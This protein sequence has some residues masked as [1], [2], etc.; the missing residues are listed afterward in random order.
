MT[1]Q[2]AADWFIPHWT[3]ADKLRKIRRS[4]GLSQTELADVLERNDRTVAAWET[5]RN[6]PKDIV[7]VA[8][9]IQMAYG[10]P[11]TW[12]LGVE[13][14]GPTDTN[15]DGGVKQSAPQPV[16]SAS[17]GEPCGAATRGST[18]RGSTT[19]DNVVYPCFAPVEDDTPATRAA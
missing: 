5:G 8:N 14:V 15:P 6:E 17:S 11:A 16:F 13:T 19:G 7:A 4:L 10:V 3:F 9:R 1:T 2:P 12:I 18:R